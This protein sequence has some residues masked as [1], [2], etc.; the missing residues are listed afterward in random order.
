MLETMPGTPPGD[1]FEHH[2]V[3]VETREQWAARQAA[4]QARA[5]EE[6]RQR[7]TAARAEAAA[8]QQ[9]AAEVKRRRSKAEVAEQVSAARRERSPGSEGAALRTDVLWRRLGLIAVLAL[10]GGVV[11][12]L[13]MFTR[14]ATNGPSDDRAAAAP[15]ASSVMTSV[16]TPSNPGPPATTSRRTRELNDTPD[17]WGGLRGTEPWSAKPGID[18]EPSGWWCVCYKTRTGEDRTACRRLATECAALR[19]MIQSEGSSAIL[20][21][22]ATPDACKHTHGPYPWIT[23]GHPGAWLPSDYSDAPRTGAEQRD[24]RRATQASGVCAL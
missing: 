23:L 2:G 14:S 8:R 16:A 19:Q 13:D 17:I 24:R 3:P 1:R 22:S 6:A 20:R 9:Q 5:Q 21:G 10:A 12:A 4:V 18:P 15:A 11:I 7:A